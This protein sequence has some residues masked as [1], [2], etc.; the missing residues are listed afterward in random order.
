MPVFQAFLSKVQPVCITVL[1]WQRLG[2]GNKKSP[3]NL[4]GKRKTGRSPRNITKTCYQGTEKRVIVALDTHAGVKGL[5]EAKMEA[6]DSQIITNLRICGL[7][8]SAAYCK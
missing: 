5:D 7:I 1:V 2:A 3:E 6:T 4:R 8:G